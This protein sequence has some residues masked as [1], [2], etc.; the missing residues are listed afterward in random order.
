MSRADDLKLKHVFQKA[1]LNWVY[2]PKP[3]G[4]APPN[5]E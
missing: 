5:W 3:N 2:N 1:T 4:T